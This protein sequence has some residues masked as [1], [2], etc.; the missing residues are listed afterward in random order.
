[1]VAS[2]VP[3]LGTALV[4]A[5]VVLYLAFSGGLGRALFLLGV[6]VLISTTDNLLRIALI[7]RQMA[8]HPAVL[9]LGVFGGLATAGP[10]G[11]VYGILLAA[12]LT[13]VTDTYRTEVRGG[14][15]A[16]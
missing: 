9:F 12:A 15:S 5:P 8:L 13:E 16:S 1:M 2:F 11:L 4:W 10:M 6:G 14:R 7:G 3:V